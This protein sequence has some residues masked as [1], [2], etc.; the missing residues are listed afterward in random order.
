MAKKI[1]KFVHVDSSDL[2]ADIGV[3]NTKSELLKSYLNIEIEQVFTD[4]FNFDKINVGKKYDVVFCFEILEHLMNPLWFLKQVKGMI[5]DGGVLYLSTPYRIQYLWAEAHFHEM[6]H[7]RIQ[8][9][10]LSPIGLNIVRKKRLR[11]IKE[12]RQFLIGFRPIYRLL[13]TGNFAPILN[14]FFSYTNIYEIRDER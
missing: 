13:R 8:R 10:L 6:S 14:I 9:W 3:K 11:F 5:K 7:K 2:V 4:D 1:S 12:Y